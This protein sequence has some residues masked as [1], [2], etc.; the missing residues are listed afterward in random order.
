[1]EIGYLLTLQPTKSVCTWLQ[2]V[3]FLVK[4]HNEGIFLPCSELKS[5]VA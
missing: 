3:V 1:M 4:F 2:C 5:H